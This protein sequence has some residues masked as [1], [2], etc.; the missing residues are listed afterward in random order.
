MIILKSKTGSEDTSS[1]ASANSYIVEA[2]IL[3]DVG[4]YREHNEDCIVYIRPADDSQLKR[5]GVLAIVADGMGGHQA[6]EV[7]SRIAVDV[8][9]RS[10]YQQD[11]EDPSLALRKAF[12]E[13]NQVIY[14]ASTQELH[15]Q[16]MGTT[17]TALVL[18]EGQVYVAHVGDSRLYRLYGDELL[19]LTE[20]HTMVMGMLKSGLITVEQARFHPN[21]NIITRALG[22]HPNVEVDIGQDLQPARVGDYF[23]L[24]S[25]G[26]YDLVADEEIKAIVVADFPHV[27]GSQLIALAKKRGG[28]DNISVGI[29]AIYAAGAITKATPET[30]ETR[31]EP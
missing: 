23:V 1:H 10:Y 15:L 22:T 3:T 25:D 12:I 2:C 9:R 17:A 20:D 16:G 6:G 26:L 28:Y 31:I 11:Q 8:I 30:R 14:T 7:A 13:A 29:L 24:C 27:A 5:S 18:R 21:K 4:C 19:L